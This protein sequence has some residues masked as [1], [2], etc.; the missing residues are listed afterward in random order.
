MD[1]LGYSIKKTKWVPVEEHHLNAV[2]EMDI[3]LALENPS[4]MENSW[5]RRLFGEE[6]NVE[7]VD[8]PIYR[9]DD[10]EEIDTDY[11]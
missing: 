3:E 11:D 2:Y 5:A 4:S 8:L 7:N 6:E 1:L 9:E 10:K